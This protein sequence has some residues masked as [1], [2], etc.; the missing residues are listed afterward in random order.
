[1]RKNAARSV[2]RLLP[3]PEGGGLDALVAEDKMLLD[4]LVLMSNGT[5]REQQT[6]V[7]ACEA[8]LTNNTEVMGWHASRRCARGSDG[9]SC[10]SGFRMVVQEALGGRAGSQRPGVQRY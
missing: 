4:A 6:F 5:C 7:W 1:M 10:G 9:P 2:V 3:Q 8:A